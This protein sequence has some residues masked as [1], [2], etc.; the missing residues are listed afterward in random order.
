MTAPLREYLEKEIGLTGQEME[1]VIGA[2]PVAKRLRTATGSE[3]ALFGIVRIYAP[4]ELF[5]KKLRDIA[6]FESGKGVSAVGLFH[7]PP[8]LRDVAA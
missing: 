4:Q 7:S 8:L 1:T 6:A 5:I 2:R 3:V